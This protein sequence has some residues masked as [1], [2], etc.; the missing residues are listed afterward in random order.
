MAPRM[1]T[2]LIHGGSH[3]AW[4]WD[5]VLSGLAAGGQSAHAFDLPGAGADPTPRGGLTL[6][7]SVSALVDQMDRSPQEPLR[8]VAHSIG[9]L[10]VGDA[11]VARP[12]RVCEIVLVA[13][14][15]L[16]AGDCA[17]DTIPE[18]RRGGYFDMAA[19]SSD[20]T[21]M[22]DFAS[23]RARFFTH[24]S[25]ER[26]HAA[27][28]LLTPQPFDVYLHP[29]RV[30]LGDLGVPL[31]Y[32]AMSDDRNFDAAVS[33]GFAAKAGA[34]ILTIAGDHC[35]MLSEPAALVR[36]LGVRAF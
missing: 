8:L 23:A 2:L 6:A 3:G 29:A 1:H 18:D 7:D 15:T 22:P 31:R 35:V 17:I 30:G 25:D 24:L 16:R 27:Y 34:P 19:A 11:V 9:A 5:D 28:D 13:A 20:N 12:D 14:V 36:A 26:A 4:C 32:V 10:P 21:L 33:A